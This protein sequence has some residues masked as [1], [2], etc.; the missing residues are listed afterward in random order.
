[1]RCF[2]IFFL[3]RGR[4][5]SMYKLQSNG[6]DKKETGKNERQRK[7]CH[8][9]SKTDGEFLIFHFHRNFHC[10]VIYRIV[11]SWL[12]IKWLRSLFFHFFHSYSFWW[13][14]VILTWLRLAFDVRPWI[15]YPW[16]VQPLELVHRDVNVIWLDMMG[17]GNAD[18][19]HR[20]LVVHLSH[21]YIPPANDDK[22]LNWSN[23]STNSNGSFIQN[24]FRLIFRQILNFNYNNQIKL[25]FK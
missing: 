13:Y 5:N 2:I 22:I 17:D 8:I 18:F 23:Y 24:E 3:L 20:P 15:V 1:M 10:L 16:I 12:E 19:L 14:W 4:F 9:S 11:Y 21:F 25:K 7:L 6:R